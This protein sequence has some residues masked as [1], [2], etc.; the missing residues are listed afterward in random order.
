MTDIKLDYDS[1]VGITKCYLREDYRQI[2]ESLS[3]GDVHPADRV[4]YE[5]TKEAIETLFEL[6]LGESL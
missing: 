5:R 6:W 1:A 4:A 2:T 3:K